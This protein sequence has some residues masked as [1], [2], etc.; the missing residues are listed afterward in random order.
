MII[1][2]DALKQKIKVDCPS[3]SNR[4]EQS[5]KEKVRQSGSSDIVL[6]LSGG[7]DSAVVTFLCARALGREKVH[8]LVLPDKDS[9]QV[10]IDDAFQLA[11]KLGIDN[12]VIDITPLLKEIGAYR[13]FWPNKIPVFL[14]IKG[15]LFKKHPDITS[16]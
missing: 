5:I 4:I 11:E 2:S 10:H 12:K 7:I 16:I 14:K 3:L 9:S 1:T 15:F 13:H 6:G 8:S